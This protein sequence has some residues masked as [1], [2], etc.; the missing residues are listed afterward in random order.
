MQTFKTIILIASI[1]ALLLLGLG[2][3]D[4]QI[5]IL[6]KH[7]TYF[8]I[9]ILFIIWTL[10][11]IGVYG[12]KCKLGLK[13]HW[14]ALLLS[15]AL[16]TFIF[17]ISPP[18]F[19]VLTDEANLIG[20]SMMMHEDKTAS[21]P[22]EGI[23]TDFEPPKFLTHIDKRPV[24]FPFLVSLVHS[25]IGYSPTN[26]FILNF[27]LGCAL[28]FSLY[29]T[30]SKVLTRT[31]GR[32]SIL[33]LAATP[34]FVVY[35]TSSGFE[36]LNTLFM[37]LSFLILI[38]VCDHRDETK[39][40]ELLLLTLLLLVQCRYES[41]IILPLFIVILLPLFWRQKFLRKMSFWGCLTPLF[42]LPVV[43]QRLLYLNHPE[44][45]KIGYNLFQ[46]VD[47][48]FSL[49]SLIQHLDD[50]I[51][52]L[53]GIDPNWGFS[54]ILS[55]LGL[56]GIYLMGKNL[57]LKKDMGLENSV[58]IAGITSFVLL[59]GIISAFFWGKFT[60]PMDNRLALVFT[61][62]VVWTS[63]YGVYH[64]SR[65]IK[66]QPAVTLAILFIFHLLF[67]WPF[68][69]AQRVVNTMALP[70]KYQNALAYLNA[71]YPNRNNT[72]ILAEHPNMYVI[73]KYSAY[74]ISSIDKMLEA[75]SE[76]TIERI[77]ALQSFNLKS[78][79]VA[80]TSKLNGPIETMM[81]AEIMITPF[82]GVKISECRYKPNLDNLNEQN[83]SPMPDN[84][85]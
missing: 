41:L 83:T 26:G 10:R 60:T 18:K 17:V 35:V 7:A 25:V 67:F 4:E 61:P 9:S 13:L 49:K 8:I 34:L 85:L 29:L 42:L 30:V 75:L 51:Y 58:F 81:V 32:L 57:V 79:E 74:R 77:V 16:V 78:G 69:A 37:V 38:E 68:G 76:T 43:W 24:F 54:I 45:N 36:V 27:I 56:V 19:K 5:K 48:P 66:H 53:L 1:L 62:F 72:L 14:P 73:H 50:N 80:A 15:L 31:Y 33:M 2:P 11:M 44:L 71:H 28:L 21:M 6:F 39:T 84:Q 22:I 65:H 46:S 55:G 63:I 47:A 59:L 40:T 12:K 70:Y 64:L 52:V 23:Y 3:S 82:W 20:V